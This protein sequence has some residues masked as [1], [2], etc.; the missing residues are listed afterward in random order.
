[1]ISDSKFQ[2]ARSCSCVFM[3]SKKTTHASVHAFKF[4]PKTRNEQRK[5]HELERAKKSPQ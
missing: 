2:D 3:K 4:K 1:M 5:S